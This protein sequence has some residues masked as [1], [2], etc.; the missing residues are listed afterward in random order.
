M[1]ARFLDRKPAPPLCVGLAH[2]HKTIPGGRDID[3]RLKTGPNC[4]FTSQIDDG[5]IGAGPA[6]GAHYKAEI[7]AITNGG[8]AR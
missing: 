2:R 1:T 7:A 5:A 3:S 8:D 4:D 6:L